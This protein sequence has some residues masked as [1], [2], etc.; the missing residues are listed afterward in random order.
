M[1]SLPVLVQLEPVGFLEEG[2]LGEPREEDG[3]AVDV[4]Q[5]EVVGLYRA[6][7]GIDRLVRVGKGVHEGGQ[8]P[9]RHDEEAV[10]DGEALG[11][12]EHRVLDDVGDA[13]AVPRPRAEGE[14]E[15]VLLVLGLEAIELASRLLVADEGAAAAVLGKLVLRQDFIGGVCVGSWDRR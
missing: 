2:V 8:A 4:H 9:P 7:G 11:A 5:V 12:A 10:L 14:G 15:D 6:R 1:S 13:R 3:V